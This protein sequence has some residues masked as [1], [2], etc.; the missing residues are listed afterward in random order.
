MTSTFDRDP[1]LLQELLEHLEFAYEDVSQ[2]T[3]A[4][5]L[6]LSRRDRNSA[7]KEIEQAQECAKKL[8][9]STTESIPNIPWKELRGLRNVIVHEY[10]EVDWDVIYDTVTIEF[11]AMIEI[12]KT[13]IGRLS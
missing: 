6:G 9:S 10:G 7:A 8:S 4:E 1:L 11:P 5:E 12:L 3:H 13:V 2:F